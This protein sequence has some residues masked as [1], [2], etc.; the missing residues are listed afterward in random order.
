MAGTISSL[1]RGGTLFSALEGGLDAG[2]QT[3]AERNLTG[4][5]SAMMMATEA[6]RSSR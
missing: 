3:V 6:S 5:T 4:A 1:S 2:E